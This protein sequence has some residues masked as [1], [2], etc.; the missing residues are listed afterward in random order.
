MRLEPSL[1]YKL[2]NNNA[3]FGSKKTE[4]KKREEISNA[5]FLLLC[6][7]KRKMISPYQLPQIAVLDAGID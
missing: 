1:K 3:T 4:E 6:F 2:C 7:S 5:K